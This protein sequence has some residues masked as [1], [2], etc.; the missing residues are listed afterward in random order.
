MLVAWT[1]FVDLVDAE[2]QKKKNGKRRLNKKKE[3]H[4]AALVSIQSMQLRL[5]KSQPRL[6]PQ[7]SGWASSM[8]ALYQPVSSMRASVMRE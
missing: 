4:L 3:Q 1:P 6:R 2:W 5:A 8:L 7:L